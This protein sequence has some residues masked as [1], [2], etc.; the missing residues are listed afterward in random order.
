[1]VTGTVTAIVQPLEAVIKQVYDPAAVNVGV[2]V[3][4]PELMP[5]AGDQEYEA[6]VTVPVGVNVRPGVAEAQVILKLGELKV[7]FGELT[8][9]TIVDVTAGAEQPLVPVTTTLYTPGPEIVAVDVVAPLNILPVPG[10][11]Q[12]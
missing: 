8:S 4:L 11:V 9:A 1:M 5:E 6:I 3:L 2:V 12:L 10:A 7:T